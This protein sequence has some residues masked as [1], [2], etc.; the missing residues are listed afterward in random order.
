[1]RMALVD[2]LIAAADHP[3]PRQV[4]ELTLRGRPAGLRR[5]AMV[6]G[7]PAVG[8]GVAPEARADA[9]GF[10]LADEIV[11]GFRWFL[12]RVV[13]PAVV[14]AAGVALVVAAWLGW[15]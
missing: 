1:M 6:V 3:D 13:L 10:D 12:R 2:A 5:L 4:I 11:A 15:P 8:V 9:P 14:V 7:N